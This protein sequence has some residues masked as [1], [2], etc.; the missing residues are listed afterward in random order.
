MEDEVDR[1]CSTHGTKRSAYRVLVEKLEGRIP[2]VRP[3][4]RLEDNINMDCR[5]MGWCGMDDMQVFKI[6]VTRIFTVY[7][8]CDTFGTAVNLTYVPWVNEVKILLI[9]FH[10]NLLDH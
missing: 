1:A 5:D 8:Y 9:R 3:R 6:K 7:N 4:H 10:L 2:L